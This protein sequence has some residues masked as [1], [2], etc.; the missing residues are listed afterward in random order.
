MPDAPDPLG[1]AFAEAVGAKDFDRM[2]TLMHP[3]I[4]FQA[5][6]PSRVWEAPD[7]ER[8]VSDV[9]RTWWGNDDIDELVSVET[10]AFA[11]IAHVNYRYRGRKEGE[12]FIAEQQAYYRARDGQIEW[13]R[14]MCTGRRQPQPD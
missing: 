5:M 8:V 9:F 4:D 13:L 11:D 14:I 7:A 10:D 12:P 2:A 6:T 1:R 3:D